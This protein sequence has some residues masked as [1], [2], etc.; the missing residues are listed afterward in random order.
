MTCGEYAHLNVARFTLH[1]A[2]LQDENGEEVLLPK[3]YLTNDIQEGVQLTV[4]LYK[5]SEDRLVATTEHPKIQLNEFAYL[6]IKEVNAF[7]AFADWGLEKDLLIPFREQH[8]RLEEGKYYLLTL[9]LDQATQRLYGSN[10]TAKFTSLADKD[11]PQ[12][13]DNKL[14]IC[15]QTGLGYRV[16]VDN[17]FVGMLYQSD[18]TTSLKPGDVVSGHI[19]NVREDGKVDVRIGSN[20]RG[21]YEDAA[22]HILNLLEKSRVLPYG[23]ASD[24]DEIRA[25]FGLS[26]KTFK[27]AIGQLY[28]QQ[29][30]KIYPNEIQIV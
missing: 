21:K 6:Q 1:G 25:F 28:K 7:G 19:Y 11:T 5:D 30:I 27:Q 29:K 13:S 23:D 8:L 17:A 26:K 18:V 20:G 12:F 14:L 16:I 10:K 24:P 15:E 22:E 9:R 3:K 4:F 2:Y